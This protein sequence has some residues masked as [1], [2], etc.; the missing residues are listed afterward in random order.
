MKQAQ[1]SK[2]QS[3]ATLAPRKTVERAL[4]L[5]L[6]GLLLFIPPIAGIFDINTLIGGIPFTVI[7]LFVVWGLLIFSAFRLSR[8]LAN[9]DD[10]ETSSIESESIDPEIKE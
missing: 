6:I 1:P 3:V 8:N 2:A 9:I 10:N 4:L 5:P 7:Y